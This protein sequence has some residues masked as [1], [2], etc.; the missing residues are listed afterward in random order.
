MSEVFGIPALA[1]LSAVL[2]LPLAGAIIALLAREA[3]KLVAIMVTVLELALAIGLLIATL[4]ANG[5]PAMTIAASTTWLPS[6]GLSYALQSDPLSIWLIVLTAFLLLIAVVA[7]VYTSANNGS[8]LQIGMTGANNGSPLQIGMVG[9]NRST[10]LQQPASYYAGLLTLATGML[11]VFLAHS[12]FLFYI[13]WEAMLVPAY[14]LIA[15]YARERGPQIAM[16]FIL[17]A[18]GG[19]LVMLAGLIGLGAV[20]ASKAS[21]F[22]GQGF[23]F[24]PDAWLQ[25]PLG[26]TIDAGTQTWLF[27]AIVIGVA[28]KI[29]LVPLHSWLPDTYAESPAPVTVMIAG[30]MSKTGVYVLLRFGVMLFPLG[31]ANWQPWLAGFAIAGIL[32]G[33]LAALAADSLQ[34]IAAYASLS[35]MGFITLGVISGNR[36]GQSGA[37]LQMVNHGVI[38]AALFLVVAMLEQ[39]AGSRHLSAFGGW[40]KKRPLFATMFMLIS[41]ATLGLPGLGSFAGEFLIMLGAWQAAPIYAVLAVLG[42]ILAAWYMVRMYQRVMHGAERNH[43]ASD[44]RGGEMLLLLP[45]TLLFFIVGIA[46]G[47]I[48]D[49][50]LAALR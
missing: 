40:G 41:L 50:L 44:M 46:P 3:A 29:P 12:I 26:L 43:P 23:G 30:V 7:P 33:A 11:G 21:S 18:L 1:Y 13:F 35:H 42:V 27:A 15:R 36:D 22:E 34:R 8:P 2:F 20:V 24:N 49:S 17:Y 4:T 48:T 25:H 6:F 38:I 9:A 45:L 10:A 16:R 39:R 19:G 37:I 32:Y 28:V 14:F 5:K 31:A 47:I